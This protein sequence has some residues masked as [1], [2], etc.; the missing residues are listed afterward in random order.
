MKITITKINLYQ[1]NILQYLY[2]PSMYNSTCN[3]I[4]TI[5]HNFTC[6]R[7]MTITSHI[8][9]INI[10]TCNTHFTDG[11]CFIELFHITENILLYGSFPSGEWSTFPWNPMEARFLK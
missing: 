8:N 1:H 10:S 5:M 4:M 7:F 11:F 2:G 6:D 9:L 3:T